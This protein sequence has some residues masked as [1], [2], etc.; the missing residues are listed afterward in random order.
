MEFLN[1]LGTHVTGL[2]DLRDAMYVAL[3]IPALILLWWRSASANKQARAALEQS[4]T[5]LDQFRLAE[6]G[7]STSLFQAASDMLGSDVVAVR[8]GGVHALMR[9][10]EQ[11]PEDFHVRVMQLFVAF[12]GTPPPHPTDPQ[13]NE[14]ADIDAI[15]QMLKR[16]SD[17]ALELE[18]EQRFYL[19]LP[20]A[21]LSGTALRASK[22]S[23]AHFVQADLSY[24]YA[25]ASDFSHSTLEHC[26]LRDGRFS[27]NF[28]L[29]QIRHSR[30]SN[31]NFRAANFHRASF[32]FVDLSA[33][34]LQYARLTEAGLS[35]VDMRGSDLTLAD[36]SGARIR[37]GRMLTPDGEVD[38]KE[39]FCLLT[40]AQ[41]DEAAADPAKPPEIHPGTV[42]A[43]TGD[44]LVWNTERGAQNWQRLDESREA[45]RVPESDQ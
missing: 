17:A 40:Q 38:D 41:L 22:F 14:R 12:L 19:Y 45:S 27:S 1:W 15:V 16:R 24:A 3:G 4:K 42:D 8:I 34:N 11:E 20:R 13:P 37:P 6:R 26:D 18:K 2:D 10:A 44:E 43:E 7:S 32:Y 30:L 35:A 39:V 5:A 23:R 9:L 25:E 31:S 29:S 36:L 28:F 21:Q 33:S